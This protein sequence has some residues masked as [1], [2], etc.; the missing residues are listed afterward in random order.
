MPQ[1]PTRRDLGR[2]Q[3]QGADRPTEINPMVAYDIGRAGQV[4]DRALGEV[5]SAFAKLSND[6]QKVE[7]DTWLAER[8]I[9]TLQAENNE[10]NRIEQ[11][12][13]EDGAG[14]EQITPTMKGIVEQQEAIPGGSEKARH[15]YKLFAAERTFEAGKWGVNTAQGRAKQYNLNRLDRRLDELTNLTAQNPMMA[16]EHF[17][18]YAE[19]VQAQVGNTIDAPSGAVRV[20]RARQNILKVGVI[21]KAKREP[22]DYARA[23]KG[24]ESAGIVP[25]DQSR[26]AS[27]AGKNDLIGKV[28]REVGISESTL[29]LFTRVESGGRAD[30]QTGSFKGLLQLSDGEYEKHG[31]AP[32]K[33]F[34][35]EQ[36]LAAGARKLK[37]ETEDFKAR[38]GRDASDLDLYMIHQQGTAGAAAHYK[39]PDEA[40]WK[41]MASTG[42]GRKKGAAWAKQAI[43][44]NIPD[45]MKKQFPG[46][47]ES[48]TSRQFVGVWYEKLERMGGETP[49]PAPSAAVMT[50]ARVRDLPKVEG[51]IQP[52]ELMSLK[53]DDFFAVTNQL[54]P[55]LAQE[56]EQRV[57]AAS[58]ALIASGSQSVISNE[59]LELAPLIA[60]PKAAEKWKQ[61]L[62]E[63]FDF[64]NI[65]NSAKQMTG[66]E[67]RQHIAAIRPTEDS[68]QFSDEEKRHYERWIKVND[69]LTKQMKANPIEFFGTQNES[70]KAAMNKIATAPP[71]REGL[72]AREQAFEVLLRLQRQEGL[73]GKDITLISKDNAEAMV[74]ELMSFRDSRQT[75]AWVTRLRE[76]YGKYTDLVWGQMSRHGA[77]MA[78]RAMSTA[79]IKG[80]NALLDV[81]VLERTLGD[82]AGKDTDRKGLV[83]QRAGVK[84][85]D[86]TEAVNSAVDEFASAIDP[87]SFGLAES[88]RQAV[89][90]VTLYH[91]L[92]NN[93]TVN[94]AA[95][96][97]A[98]D[99]YGEKLSV[100]NR[101]LIPSEVYGG[102]F[103]RRDLRIGIDRWTTLFK[104]SA[105]NVYVPLPAQGKFVPDG[106]DRQ[107]YLNF[108]AASGRLVT[109]NELKGVHVLDHDNQR[110]LVDTQEGLKPL[111][112]D[113]ETL[114]KNIPPA[115]NNPFSDR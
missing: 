6:K 79:N 25:K 55:F 1:L 34:D 110:V 62:D 72:P 19:E 82:A 105:E 5:S 64:H 51:T 107:R 77:P 65:Y 96:K 78:F 69:E 40:A 52:A 83:R 114:R 26:L 32:G 97:A 95:R 59:D 100:H 57:Q 27:P 11:E 29:R 4:W 50:G 41:N 15:Q 111:F 12:A 21:E 7:D 75:D 81:L 68:G 46:G 93:M 80:Q 56:M 35:P 8:K 22:L 38:T 37:K 99:F 76:Q 98:N 67:R 20:E 24:L 89:E 14:F 102:P 73:D 101:V 63:S 103:E 23:L 88:Y 91:M 90:K 9:E 47:V 10:R 61:A 66:S 2:V 92:A 39:R 54:K 43:W 71:G 58:A 60:G 115:S 70:G 108:V 33:I 36:N 17:K 16:A 87:A 106:Y 86:L 18:L 113:W 28:A 30:A 104:D 13:A 109:D 45:D 112:W 94:E 53:P 49:T 42:E 3:V 85:S 84:E 44:G 31:G 74:N 48:V